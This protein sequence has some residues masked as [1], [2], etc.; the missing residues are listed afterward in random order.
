MFRSVD[1]DLT[2]RARVLEDGSFRMTTYDKYD[3]AVAGSHRVQVMPYRNPDG[4]LAIPVH[5]KYLKYLTS[6]LQLEVS[7]E[8]K[9][10]FDIEVEMR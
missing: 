10:H 8:D 4:S 9:N 5:P 7:S 6:E 1:T 3:G 2:A